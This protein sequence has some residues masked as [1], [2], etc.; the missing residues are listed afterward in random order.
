MS[1]ITTEIIVAE[2][3]LNLCWDD[4]MKKLCVGY[5]LNFE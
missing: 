1:K 5:Y 3:K 4:G 2:S